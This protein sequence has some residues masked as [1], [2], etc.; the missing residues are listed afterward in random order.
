MS[1]LTPPGIVAAQFADRGLNLRPYLST[2]RVWAMRPIGQ[3]SQ[4]LVAIP[5][6]PTVHR[7]T[8][9]AEAFGDLGDRHAGLDFQNCSIPLFRHVQLHQHSAECYAS[10]G[11]DL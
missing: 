2:V 11:T 5:P 8:R 6:H 7:R 3:P 9:D 4:S 10:G 1:V